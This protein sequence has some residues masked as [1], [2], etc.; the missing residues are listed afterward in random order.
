M[1]Y[2][3]FCLPL[4]LGSMALAKPDPAGDAKKAIKD[5]Y[6]EMAKDFMDKKF[7]AFS[8]IMTEDF[9]ASR[10]GHPEQLTRDQVIKDFSAQRDKLSDIRW[11]K[12]IEKLDLKDGVAHV[13]VDGKM[14]GTMNFG[15][16][17]H[18]SLDLKAKSEDDWIKIGSDWKLKS[19]H[20]TDITV[21]VDG[22]VTPIG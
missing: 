12:K 11:T 7:T 8:D 21:K 3:A 19:S 2:Y 9:Q 6:S 17:K 10:E 4:V 1:K 22:K 18:H 15:D 5:V 20:T 13:L 16:G 14:R